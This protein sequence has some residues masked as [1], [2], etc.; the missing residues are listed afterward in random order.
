V[1]ER[2]QTLA[3]AFDRG[4]AGNAEILDQEFVQFLG[5]QV[6]DP[7]TRFDLED[8]GCFHPQV[9]GASLN[10]VIGFLGNPGAV[11]NVHGS[12]VFVTV[13][14]ANA[15]NVVK[16][17]LHYTS[18]QQVCERVTHMAYPMAP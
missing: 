14:F 16:T 12:E 8:L 6:V 7:V 2:L 9:E 15:M 10:E 18:F 17:K 1:I 4:I 13:N 5:F 3:D 11:E